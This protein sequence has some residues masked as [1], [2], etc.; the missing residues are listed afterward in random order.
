MV[1]K[2]RIMHEGTLCHSLGGVPLPLLTITNF[3]AKGRKKC[4]LVLGRQHPGE[5]NGSIVLEGFLKFICSENP[6][7]NLIRD[8]Y[9][10]KVVP[11]LNVDGTIAGNYR[12]S[13]GGKD[14]NRLFKDKNHFLFP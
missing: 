2:G 11:M 8:K 6:G 4:I 9:V 12:T 13:L 5:S 7:A 3:S 10:L 14:L 1:G